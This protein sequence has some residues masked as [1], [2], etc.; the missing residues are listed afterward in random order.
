MD[1]RIFITGMGICREGPSHIETPKPVKTV[2]RAEELTL[3]ALSAALKQIRN[4]ELD[5]TGIVFGI[6]NAIDKCKAEFFK[7][8]VSEGPIGAS[9]L[10][11]PYTSHNAITAQA[12]IAFGIKGEALTIVSG[13]SSFLKA[14]G[15]GFELLHRGVMNAVIAG[16]VSENGAMV[17]IMESLTPDEAQKKKEEGVC[18]REVIGYNDTLLQGE[19]MIKTIEESFSMVEG[20]IEGKNKLVIF[21]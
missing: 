18:L 5:T 15:Y 8:L 14:V 9:P 7:G 21:H 13:A 16:G 1:T 2:L 10:L 6:D 20:F 17:I 3:A 12:T 19:V 11:F 4:L